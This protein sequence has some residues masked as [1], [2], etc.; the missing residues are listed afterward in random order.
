MADFV[1]A[2]DRL[3]RWTGNRPAYPTEP[4]HRA[5]RE[6]ESA[7]TWRLI[8][9]RYAELDAGQRRGEVLRATL[10]LDYSA[11][12]QLPVWDDQC[13][14]RNSRN[15]WA[16]N[17]VAAVKFGLRAC[18]RSGELSREL[19]KA[20]ANQY[21][22]HLPGDGKKLTKEQVLAEAGIIDNERQPL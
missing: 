6:A 15:A 16:Q 18:M 4:W 3:Q 7:D 10:W 14:A 22:V 5:L 8:A 19:E 20:T 9:A 12:E 1:T 13:G 17:H 21:T 2:L 11:D